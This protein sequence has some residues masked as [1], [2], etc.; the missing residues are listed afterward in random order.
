MRATMALKRYERMTPGPASRIVTELPRKSPTPIAPPIVIMV[1]WR[2]VSARL[3]SGELSG[4]SATLKAIGARGG[5]ACLLPP[6]DVTKYL[7]ELVNLLEGVV[8]D[9]RCAVDTDVEASAQALHQSWS[10]HVAVTNANAAVRHDLGDN[11]W[12]DVG[13]FKAKRG[14]AFG[15][16]GGVVN[17][18][19]D[20]ADS[21]QDLEH[22]GRKC[23]FV[24]AD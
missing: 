16:A 17:A 19:D 18:V 24:L 7:P 21:L 13:K 10:V 9:K 6:N 12:R 20:G 8:V 2:C 14:N 11:R 5:V 23:S 15:Q 1:S 3:S 4:G 22:L